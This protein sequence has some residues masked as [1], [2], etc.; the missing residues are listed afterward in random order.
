MTHSISAPGDEDSGQLPGLI[1]K[2]NST[3][4]GVGLQEMEQKSSLGQEKSWIL[5]SQSTKA[6]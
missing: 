5:N 4:V 2:G 6:A 1:P 3:V